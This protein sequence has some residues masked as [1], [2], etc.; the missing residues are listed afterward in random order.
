MRGGKFLADQRVAFEPLPHPPALTA[1]KLARYLPVSGSEVTRC[2]L[3]VGPP[4][5]LLAVLP[6]TH[7]VDTG[8]L[9]RDLGGPV[10]LASDREV[11]ALFPDCEG[12]VVPP[13]GTPYGLKTLPDDAL[14]PD[15][16][17]VL[18]T[19]TH[20]AAIRLRCRDFERLERPRRLRCASK[21]APAGV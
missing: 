1:R 2:V 13:F 8:Q 19:H 3:L 18:E 7:Q 12:G 11:G 9:T 16:L 20:V 5:Y 6:A 4:G 17:L 21:P 10:R 14:A 15:T